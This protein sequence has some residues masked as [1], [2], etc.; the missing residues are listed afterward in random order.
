MPIS[1]NPIAYQNFKALEACTSCCCTSEE[2]RREQQFTYLPRYQMHHTKSHRRRPARLAHV[3]RLG[4][5]LDAR[6]VS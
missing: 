4:V 6:P 3:V 5:R 2:T 1:R